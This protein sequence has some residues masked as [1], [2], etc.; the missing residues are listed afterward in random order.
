MCNMFNR[1][2]HYFRAPPPHQ[3]DNSAELI[4]TRNIRGTPAAT[5]KLRISRGLDG[6]RSGQMY[7]IHEYSSGEY[8][9][10]DVNRRVTNL[11][12]CLGWKRNMSF[13]FYVTFK[14]YVME[15]TP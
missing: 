4:M 8:S 1:F 14:P 13:V 10:T 6:T 9:E 5:S 15:K 2:L 11:N 12:V 7:D 3:R